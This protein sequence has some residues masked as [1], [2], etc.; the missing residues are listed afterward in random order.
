M[1]ILSLST[2]S[3]VLV[4][5]KVCHYNDIKI[6]AHLSEVLLVPLVSSPVR[7]D[8]KS[9]AITQPYQATN[10]FCDRSQ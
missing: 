5:K 8:R 9:D 4:V 7:L 1:D 6:L 10:H 2:S 3:S